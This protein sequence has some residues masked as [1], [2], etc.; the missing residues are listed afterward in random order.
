VLS[1][2]SHGLA[3]DVV[4]GWFAF[5]R[6]RAPPGWRTGRGLAGIGVVVADDLPAV[7]RGAVAMPQAEHPAFQRGNCSPVFARQCPL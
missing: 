3:E 5:R 1:G 2:Y 4:R 7:A 6:R